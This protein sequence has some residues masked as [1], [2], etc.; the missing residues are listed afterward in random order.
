MPGI[1]EFPQVAEDRYKIAQDY[2]FANYVCTSG[3]H[4]PLD[5]RLFRKEEACK[6]LKQPFRNHTVLA[7]DLIVWVCERQIPGDFTTDSYFTNADILNHIH[8]R[9][10]RCGRPRGYVGDLKFNRQVQWKCQT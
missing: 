3:K 6:A 1:I 9:T 2:L 8:S 10:D 5:F 4:Y 7:C